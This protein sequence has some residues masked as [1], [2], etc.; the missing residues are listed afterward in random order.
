MPKFPSKIK[1]INIKVKVIILWIWKGHFS[2]L[3]EHFC[4]VCQKVEGHGPSAPPVPTSLIIELSLLP[5]NRENANSV[6]S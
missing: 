2:I 3:K 4:R 1:V 5:R 6:L